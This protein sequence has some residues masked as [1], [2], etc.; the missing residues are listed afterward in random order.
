MIKDTITELQNGGGSKDRNHHYAIQSM[1]GESMCTYFSIIY[2]TGQNLPWRRMWWS[3]C[4]KSSKNNKIIGCKNIFSLRQFRLGEGVG[5]IDALEFRGDVQLVACNDIH[6]DR[7]IMVLRGLGHRIFANH[8]GMTLGAVL[9][10]L[11]VLLQ[12][13]SCSLLLIVA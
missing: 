6:I 11:I 4:T 7:S 5:G 1:Y 13:A 12:S 3:K 10:E 2:I 8:A 9:V